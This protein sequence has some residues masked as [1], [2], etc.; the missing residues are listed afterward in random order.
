[1]T[2]ETAD[3]DGMNVSLKETAPLGVDVATEATVPTETIDGGGT[4]V[5]EKLYK[6]DDRFVTVE[7][8]VGDGETADGD[9]TCMDVTLKAVPLEVEVAIE[10]TVPTDKTDGSGGGTGVIEELCKADD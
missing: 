1:M 9:C 6:A 10:A 4:G 2:V 5:I 7:T 3:G 8:T